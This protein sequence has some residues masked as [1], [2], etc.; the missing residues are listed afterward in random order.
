MSLC[1]LPMDLTCLWLN[2]SIKDSFEF[3]EF[4]ELLQLS[5]AGSTLTLSTYI[6]FSVYITCKLFRGIEFYFLNV[7]ANNRNS[8]LIKGDFD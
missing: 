7:R 4:F 6:I 1:A 3:F 2:H 5:L 8:G